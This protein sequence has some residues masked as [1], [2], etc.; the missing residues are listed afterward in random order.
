MYAW[1]T[2]QMPWQIH[3]RT[4]ALRPL[5]PD[6]TPPADLVVSRSCARGVI[7]APL[8]PVAD[9]R[10]GTPDSPCNACGSGCS[11]RAWLGH[12]HFIEEHVQ[13]RCDRTCEQ[14]EKLV[15]LPLDP[16]TKW[17]VPHHCLQHR[18]AH[19]LDVPRTPV[20]LRLGCTTAKDV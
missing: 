7:P 18:E 4:Q 15:G 3:G 6:D 12:A 14:V 8:S 1:L 5:S 9:R 16:Q 13:H 10:L 11:V 17:C 2:V 19:L 20:A